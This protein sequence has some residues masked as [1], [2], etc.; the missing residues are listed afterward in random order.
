MWDAV[1]LRRA[2]LCAAPA[3]IASGY[4]RFAISAD[5]EHEDDH[6]AHDQNL[7]SRRIT[8]ERHGGDIIAD[9]LLSNSGR[10]L[11]ESCS[12]EGQAIRFSVDRARKTF[13]PLRGKV[14]MVNVPGRFLVAYRNGEPEIEMNVMPGAPRT[15]T[16]EL[17]SQV[18]Y[19]RFNPTWTVPQSILRQP[20]WQDRLQRPNWLRDNGFSHSGGTLVQAPGLNNAMGVVKIR[21]RSAGNILLHDTNQPQGFDNPDA[22]E[23]NG[24]VRLEKP[25]ELAAWIL[26]IPLSHAVRMQKSGDRRDH[27]DVSNVQA[28]LTY[29]TAW[30]TGNSEIEYYR[31][32][33]RKMGPENNLGCARR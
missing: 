30:P 20:I 12:R 8:G 15:P 23:S 32:I 17:I 19:V 22:F 27:R 18:E 26:G 11:S 6:D 31:D 29:L 16:P 14:I 7:A 33:Y 1:V 5:S 28:S 24:C 21:M 2:F 25:M 3:I 4:P 10:R 13:I 9:L